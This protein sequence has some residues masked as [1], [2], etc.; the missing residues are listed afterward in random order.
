MPRYV[1]ERDFPGAGKL[2]PQELKDM[3]RKSRD[4]LNQM[5][6]QIQW[7]QTY[8]ADDK[9]YCVYI[10]ADEEMIR[11]HAERGGFPVTRI[12]RVR[13]VIDLTTAEQEAGMG[14]SAMNDATSGRATT[15]NGP[16]RRRSNAPWTGV[17]RRLAAVA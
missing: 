15:Y 9:A 17:E 8:V 13:A 14:F 1:I 10:A 16:E 6:P 12:S 5:G 11:D 4:V 2:S 7:H 3:A